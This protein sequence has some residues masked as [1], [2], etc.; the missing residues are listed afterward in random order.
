[1]N[2]VFRALDDETRRKILT[3]LSE[4][5]SLTVGEIHDQFEISKPSISHHLTILRNAELVTSEK[6]GQ[7]VHYTLH[8]TVLQD[9]LAW[10]MNLNK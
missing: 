5:G 7:Y 6:K 9:L 2:D 10:M 1:M 8:T 4:K 3:L